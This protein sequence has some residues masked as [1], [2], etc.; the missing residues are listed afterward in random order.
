MRGQVIVA[1]HSADL[2]RWLQPDEILVLD[3]VEGETQFTWADSL[4]LS[5]WLQEYTLSELWLMGTLG[6]RP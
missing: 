2:I 1:T 4:D 5:E 6:G 3:K